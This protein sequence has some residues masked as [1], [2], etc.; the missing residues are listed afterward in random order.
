MKKVDG[1]GQL[2]QIQIRL[3]ET[4][5]AEN[6]DEREIYWIGLYQNLVNSSPGGYSHSEE[7]IRKI[8]DSKRGEKNPMFGQKVTEEHRKKMVDG[9]RKSE[10]FK[11]S[12][13]SEEFKKKVSERASIT[14]ILLDENLNSIR[15]FRNCRECAEFLGY[16]ETNV[17]NAVRFSR[18]LGRWIKKVYWVV[19]KDSIEQSIQKIKNEPKNQYVLTNKKF[20]KY[21]GGRK[22]LDESA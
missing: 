20:G 3:L 21:G 17:T 19:R 10:K 13:Q 12:R 11:I 15:E 7:T 4:C 5:H 8:A 18:P 22:K 2:D 1:A 6:V 16:K 14:L 9:M